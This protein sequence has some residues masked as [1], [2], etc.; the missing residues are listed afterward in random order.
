MRGIFGAC[1]HPQV[2]HG[3]SRRHRDDIS[4]SGDEEDVSEVDSEIARQVASEEAGMKL[5]YKHRKLEAARGD[6]NELEQLV[7][8]QLAGL[9]R[10]ASW[11]KSYLVSSMLLGKEAMQMAVVTLGTTKQPLPGFTGRVAAPTE[12]G[13]M[14]YNYELAA[15]MPPKLPSLNHSQRT[16]GVQL[17]PHISDTGLTAHKATASPL[18]LSAVPTAQALQPVTPIPESAAGIRMSDIAHTSAVREYEAGLRSGD[19][20]REPSV[21]ATVIRPISGSAVH[22]EPHHREHERYESS[23]VTG[24]SGYRSEQH[25][26]KGVMGTIKDAAGSVAHAVGLGGSGE[27]KEDDTRREA[28]SSDTGRYDKGVTRREEYSDIDM[29]GSRDQRATADA[30]SE[31]RQGGGETVVCGRKE[32]SEVEDRPYVKERVTRILEHN[33]V[34]KEYVTQVKFAGEHALPSGEK[35]MLGAPQTRIVETTPPGPKCPQG[36]HQQHGITA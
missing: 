34:E 27:D 24:G 25:E 10:D 12:H 3:G 13:E 2:G 18:E 7:A 16:W 14:G 28:Y 31:L 26:S 19:S 33:P 22:A 35:E 17:L 5:N 23:A 6:Y 21:S 20:Y 36:M 4:S 15:A 11:L 8:G 1:M 32:F 9:A 30:A 29:A